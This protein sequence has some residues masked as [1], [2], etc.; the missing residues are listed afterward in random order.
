V[1]ERALPAVAYSDWDLLYGFNEPEDGFVWT[2]FAFGIR[3][4]SGEPHIGLVVLYPHNDGVLHVYDPSGGSRDYSLVK[5]ENWLLLVC[6]PHRSQFDF[7]V[8][9][10]RTLSEDVRELGVMLR[11]AH[12]TAT[13]E[14]LEE[15]GEIN[16]GVPGVWVPA[17]RHLPGKLLARQLLE[18]YIGPGVFISYLD[19]RKEIP[20]LELA[21]F[22]PAWAPRGTTR[23]IKLKI[24]RDV[25]DVQLRQ[26]SNEDGRYCLSHL[27][28]T[29]LRGLV[30]LK[31]Y[32][33]WRGVLKPLDIHWIDEE[34]RELRPAQAMHWRG[35]GFGALPAVENMARVAG[36]VSYSFFLGTGA[37]WFVKMTK[38]Y[39]KLTGRRISACGPVLDWGIGCGR[40][41]RFFT[42]G[43]PKLYG[44][45]IDAVNIEWCKQNLPWIEAVQTSPDPP[46][47]FADGMF[48]LVYG[49][50]VMTHL[51]AADQLAW[52]AELARVTKPGGYC[53]LTVL[54][55]LSWFIRFFPDGRSAE[56]LE[57]FIRDGVM[58]DGSLDVGVDADRPGVYRNISHTSAYIFRVWAEYFEVVEIIHGFADL[59]SLVVLRRR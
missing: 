8:S 50:S 54:N 5:G 36:L 15:A 59:Q 9:P 14:E 38:L 2:N 56:Q 24:N 6:A 19:Q 46:L 29:A 18:S 52:L 47:P 37:S 48:E 57:S 40:I 35:N 27:P 11:I 17:A 31:R 1:L 45:D 42:P 33:S 41:A 25:V 39:R 44:V 23:M 28:E 30:N 16:D 43:K 34:G 53:L 49:H 26:D 20:I 10:Q 3:F 13:R 21:L 7:G 22:P 32:M 51:S 12:R 4:G 58:D 55:E